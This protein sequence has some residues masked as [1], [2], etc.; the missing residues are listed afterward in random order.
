MVQQPNLPYLFHHS[1]SAQHV[2]GFEVDKDD[3]FFT[4]ISYELQ[5]KKLNKAPLNRDG[6]TLQQIYLHSKQIHQE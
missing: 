3:L 4:I 1:H 6:R 2:E 5:K